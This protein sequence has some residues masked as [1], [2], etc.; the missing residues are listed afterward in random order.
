MFS[1]S[2]LSTVIK[3]LKKGTNE[4]NKLKGK[5]EG[6]VRKWSDL[7]V[8]VFGSQPRFYDYFIPSYPKFK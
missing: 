7:L 5:K 4:V 1:S 6:E 8:V 3:N 2:T